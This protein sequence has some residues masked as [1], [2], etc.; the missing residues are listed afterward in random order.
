MAAAGLES[1]FEKATVSRCQQDECRYN[2]YLPME[3]EASMTIAG[4]GTED[5]GGRRNAC[6]PGWPWPSYLLAQRFNCFRRDLLPQHLASALSKGQR[7][8]R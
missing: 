6:S 7:R 8:R 2:T 4:R 5:F 1:R 3:Q